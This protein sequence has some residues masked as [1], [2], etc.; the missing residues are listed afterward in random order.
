MNK[1][2]KTI[3][4]YLPQFHR[5]KENDEWWGEGYTEW[6]AV[7]AASALFEGHKQP[8]EPLNNNY[9]DLLD[10]STM[11]WQ[12]ALMKKYGIDGQCFYHYYFQDGRKILEKPAEN[13]LKWKEI[14]M[15]FFFC[16]DPHSWT[17]TWSN[18]VGISW[19]EKFEKISNMENGI[20]L[21]Q[22]YGNHS[23]WEKHFMYLLP[24]FKDERYMKVDNAPIFMIHTP[25]QIYCLNQMVSKWRQLAKDN[26]FSDLYIIAENITY[27]TKVADA[28]LF[29]T[30]GT[31]WHLEKK[32]THTG[33]DYDDMWKTLL[34]TPALKNCT[35]FFE[36]MANRDDTPRRGSNGIIAENFSIDKF[37]DYMTQLY[38]KSIILGNEF[39]FINAWNEWGEGMYIEPDEEHR[40]AYLEAVKK[41]QEQACN[42]DIKYS[43]HPDIALMQEY[44]NKLQEKNISICRV[45]RCM[46][47]WM[48]LREKEINLGEYL[49]SQGVYTIAI[50]GMGILGKHFIYEI[51]HSNTKVKI[52]YLIDRKSEKHNLKYEII[53]PERNL[54]SVDAIVVTAINDFDEITDMLRDK[55]KAKILSLEEL[56]YES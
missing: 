35:T 52:Q 36:G 12:V 6:T 53:H 46:D 55:T 21:E 29:R 16:W 44:G 39:V 13:L 14:D 48:Q 5:V 24:F 11:Q 40:F 43:E 37:C 7:K 28:V 33:F 10:K 27:N 3:T 8:K 22:K 9:Y 15:P 2:I 1:A 47:K 32:S 56:V 4:M 31:F 19:S 45:N 26:G 42:I 18:I 54:W 50:Y 38:K 20:L 41:A 23:V 25:E 30:P 34:K 49:V 17:R 51:E